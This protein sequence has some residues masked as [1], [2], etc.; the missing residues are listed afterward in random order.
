MQTLYYVP[1]F[2]ILFALLS[3]KVTSNRCKEKK[4]STDNSSCS[5][6]LQKSIRAQANAAEYIPISILVLFIGELAG[7]HMV[8]LH[9]CYIALFVSR[10]LSPIGIMTDN[11]KLRAAGFGINIFILVVASIYDLYLSFV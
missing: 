2:G 3:I 1:F 7:A 8:Y 10:V 6:M 11:H 5:E 4:F 9:V